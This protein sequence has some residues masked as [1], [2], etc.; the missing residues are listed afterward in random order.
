MT[1]YGIIG[2]II[3]IIILLVTLHGMFW[4]QYDES[5]GYQYHPTKEALDSMKIVQK[6]YI[7]WPIDQEQDFKYSK[8]P[9]DKVKV[10]DQIEEVL[11]ETLQAPNV[12]SK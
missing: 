10:D 5:G 1:I 2:I 7:E 4:P 8:I 6:Q 11:L 12:A 9:P 3:F